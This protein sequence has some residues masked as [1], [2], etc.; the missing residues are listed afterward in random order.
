M[1]SQKEALQRIITTLAN[2]N[3]ELHNFIETLSHLLAG[4]QVNSSQVVSDLEEEFDTLFSMLEETKESMTNTIKQ[5]QARKSHELQNQ[6]T[7]STNALESAEE[8]LEFAQ[9]A[10]DIKDEDEFTKGDDG[11]RFPPH[12]EAQSLG[13]HDPPDGGLFTGAPASPGPSLPSRPQ[14]SRN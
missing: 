8:L 10:L 12:H 6:L 7:Q 5:E 2:K 9:H 11:S 1:D 13:Q 14:S 4:V 3:D